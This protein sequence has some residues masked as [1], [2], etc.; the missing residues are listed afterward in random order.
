MVVTS[1]PGTRAVQKVTQTIPI[2][3]VSVGGPAEKTV[4]S[5]I[6]RAAEEGCGRPDVSD[7]VVARLL[8]E[9]AHRASSLPR[10]LYR[11]A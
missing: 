8:D 4:W 1:A 3:F 6:L 7:I 5:A 10:L 2:V 11:D 9:V